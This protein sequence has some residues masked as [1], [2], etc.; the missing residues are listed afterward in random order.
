MGSGGRNR[1]MYFDKHIRN[2]STAESYMDALKNSPYRTH[3]R[4]ALAL[5]GQ[6]QALLKGADAKIKEG[7][8]INEDTK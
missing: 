5:K 6:Y 8:I 2:T 7:N 1:D 4:M 3:K